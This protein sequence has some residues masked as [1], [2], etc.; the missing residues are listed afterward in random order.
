MYVDTLINYCFI[1]KF[2]FILHMLYEAFTFYLH[3]NSN[4]LVTAL[5]ILSIHRT[6][7]CLNNYATTASAFS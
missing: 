3:I 4:L 6:T 5:N 7:P 2:N 1:S